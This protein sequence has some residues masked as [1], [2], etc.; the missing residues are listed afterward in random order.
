MIL[1]FVAALGAEEWSDT[2]ARVLDS[3]VI[4]KMDRTRPFD[5]NDQSSSEASGFVVDAA[6]GLVMTNRHV[7]TTGPTLAHAIFHNQ[8]EVDLVPV[9]AD[10]VHDFGL[11][12]YDPRKLE[13]IEPISLELAPEAARVGTE[14][15]VMG[16]DAGRR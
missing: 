3:C 12:R 1:L 13:H 10:P 16:N 4:I 15:R 5:G 9:Y 6:R 11:F 2:I 14:I 8:E 7:A